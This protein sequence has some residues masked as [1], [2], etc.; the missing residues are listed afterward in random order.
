M[1]SFKTDKA[2]LC[3]GDLIPDFV[4]P[5][6]SLRS[7]LKE[8]KR[9]KGVA[10]EVELRCG[11]TSGNS[12]CGLA[13]LGIPSYIFAKVGDDYQ[14]KLLRNDLIENGVRTDYL[15]VDDKAPSAVNMIVIDEFG[16]RFP[17]QWPRTGSAYAN[18]KA[19][20][21]P[22]SI[23]DKIGWVLFEGVTLWKDPTGSSY[24][25]LAERCYSA[26]IPIS[27][28]LNLHAEKVGWPEDYAR[29]VRRVV[30][31][32]SIV[33]GSLEEEY[34]FL[35]EHPRQLV[36]NTRSV[37]ARDGKNGCTLYSNEGEYSVGIYPV[38]VTDT[39]GAGDIFNS[40]FIAAVVLGLPLKECLA[41]GN[42]CGNYS[43]GLKGG[44]S[45]PDRKTLLQFIE[46]N[47]IPYR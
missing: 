43:V 46:K 38:E 4:I 24:L 30:E 25:D 31:L 8:D 9:A 20:E 39:I 7:S 29:K 16:E 40:G 10:S 22:E 26:G 18:I 33:F 5:Y 35:T 34:P 1:Q 17:F 11:G 3:A 45:C 15:L 37:I 12:S 42:A 19:E 6:G 41:W 13:K 36:T 32:S 23:L 2:V 14:G 27:I 21:I 47:G 28:D 44:R